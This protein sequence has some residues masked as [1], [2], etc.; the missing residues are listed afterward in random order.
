MHRTRYR[1]R[2][3]A[4]DQ[5]PLRQR[6]REI[7]AVR[8]R[9]GYRRVHTL[10]RREGW[11]VNVKRVYRLYRLDGLSLR[12]KAR[13]KRVS[14][15]RAVPLPPQSPNEQWSM[16]FMSDSL[17]DGRRF[18]VLTLV[19]NMS[20][21][22][23]AIVVDRSFSGTRVVAVLNRLEATWGV[24][25]S[26][27]VDNGPEF[28]SKAL[29]D[30]AHRHRIKLVFSRPGTPT[31]NP[32]IEAFNGRFRAECLDQHWFASLE[33]ARQIIEAWRIDYNEVRPHTALDHQTPAAYKAAY[34]Q[35]QA[36]QAREETG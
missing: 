24:P 32:Y 6:I 30:W 34:L 12:L 16:D 8:V 22:S 15:P 2:S 11:P 28:S 23:P 7:A 14:A 13:K 1:Y 27:Q 36:R 33:E 35:D 10:L 25:Q 17:Y 26:I 18:R 19:D 21:E 3:R 4:Q 20:R 31:D 29:D 5:G 9:Y